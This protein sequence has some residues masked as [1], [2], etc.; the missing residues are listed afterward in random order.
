MFRTS[1]VASSNPG[2]V[3]Q[4]HQQQCPSQMHIQKF[5]G[6]PMN[7]LGAGQMQPQQCMQGMQGV[8]VPDLSSLAAGLSLQNN[9]LIN[10]GG[11]V[12]CPQSSHNRD[13]YNKGLWTFLP[14]DGSANLLDCGW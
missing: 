9:N 7:P 10:M 3:G 1:S 5:L 2:V 6:M 4:Q 14:G 8:G 13:F 12:Q 11:H